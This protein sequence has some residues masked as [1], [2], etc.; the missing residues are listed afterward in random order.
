MV[1]ILPVR[2]ARAP[3]GGQDEALLL[4][5]EHHQEVR[6][7]RLRMAC[8]LLLLGA[9]AWVGRA[10]IDLTGGDPDAGTGNGLLWAGA[11]LVTLGAALAA[12]TSVDHAPFWLQ[13]IVAVCA[14]LAL[15]MVL[16]AGNDMFSDS[17]AKAAGGFGAVLTIGSAI[18]FGK[19]KPVSKH[20]GSHKG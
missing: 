15:W 6:M 20:K 3:P 19:A 8:L 7:T 16:L 12:F 14:P 18:A 13:L 10:A 9:L 17:Q 2:V 4:V 1:P 11:L 5:R